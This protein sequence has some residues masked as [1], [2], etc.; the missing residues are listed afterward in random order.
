MQSNRIYDFSTKFVVNEHPKYKYLPGI[1]AGLNFSYLNYTGRT[2]LDTVH[3]RG[4]DKYTGIWL[5]GGLF[6]VDSTALFNFDAAGKLC[7]LGDYAG[8][9]TIQGFLRQYFS[10]SRNSYIKVNALIESKMANPFFTRYIGNHDYWVNDFKNIKTFSLE[11]KYVNERLR[12]ELGIGWTN[13][14][15]YVYFDTTAMPVQSSKNIMVL[16]AWG[17]QKFKAGNFHFD[18]TVYVQKS[19]EEDVLSLPL[20]AVYSHNYYKNAF[21]KKVLRFTIGLDFF[22]N[23][24]FYADKY[25]PSTMQFYN[26]RTEKTGGYP[27]LDA[28]LDFGIK[29]AHIFL[30]YEHVNYYFTNGEYFSALDYPINPAMFKFGIVWN[31]FD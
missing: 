31:F 8:N 30:K 2:S 13:T 1:Y 25:Q 12:T 29:R 26:Q 4:T 9:F 17:K 14:I 18:Q 6:N 27:K 10:S 24:K 23:T 28:F 19:T 5:T 16:T 22:Y 15:D 21:F 3:N 11:G 20:V 7:L